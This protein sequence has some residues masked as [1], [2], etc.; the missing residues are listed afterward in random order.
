MRLGAQHLAI[1]LVGWL[2]AGP[3]RAADP[4]GF[5]F[6]AGFNAS[7]GLSFAFSRPLETFLADGTRVAPGIPRYAAASAPSLRWVQPLRRRRIRG[8]AP[9]RK[10]SIPA[11]WRRP[12]HPDF[13][14][15]WN[16]GV[17][18]TPRRRNRPTTPSTAP[19]R[20]GNRQAHSS[21]A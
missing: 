4:K 18:A 7:P 19:S 14:R 17:S 1:L 13:A 10:A 8:S 2:A 15:A 6:D 12:L 5:R 3:L 16:R 21:T 11:G 20:N 9:R